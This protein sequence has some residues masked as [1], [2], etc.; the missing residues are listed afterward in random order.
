MSHTTRPTV[1]QRLISYAA[2]AVLT[3]GFAFLAFFAGFA[4]SWFR[5]PEVRYPV[6]DVPELVQEQFRVY[7]EA[8]RLIDDEF[9]AVE[10]LDTTELVGGAIAGTVE[11]LDDPHTTWV[12][13]A[14]ADIL[15]EDLS[16][17]FQGI[18]ATV[19]MVDG[20]LTI[21][22]PLPSSP[23]AEAGLRPGDVIVSVNG[24][25]IGGMPLLEAVGLVRGPEGTSVDL[26]I[27]RTQED[28]SVIEIDMTITRRRFD[29]PTVEYELLPEGIA[30][31][32]LAEFN[33]RA[34][35]QV[36]QAL[37]DLLSEE[38][39]GL[40]LDL[41]NNPGGYL[42]EAIGVT[43]QF[44][45]GDKLLMIERSSDG[46]EVEYDTQRNG[47]AT[48]IDL[49]VLVNGFSAS[50]SE[51]TAGA[52]QDYG[53][54]VLIG[55]QTYGKGSMQIPYTLSDGSSLILTVARWYTP[56]DRLIDGDG[57]TPDII[58]EPTEEDLL[59]EIDVQLDAAIN[60]LREG[61]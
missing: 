30:Y 32:K 20:R 22:E 13:P 51:I 39:I 58:V 47:L 10:P 3:G 54:G 29:V 53:R 2:T 11:T 45:E 19:N 40:I 38:P 26:R 33:A 6:G 48:D 36:R 4:S 50:A 52:I 31:L 7:W 16:G 55:S 34:T 42:D 28:G 49:A 17:S 41:R 24:E 27:E 25:D 21:I 9:Y 46:D 14:T 43:S 18:G 5:Q 60:Y 15:A 44:I 23:A 12:D 57:L 61:Q 59:A 56:A 35:S 1:G 37:R 8:W